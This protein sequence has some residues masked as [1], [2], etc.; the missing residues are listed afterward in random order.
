MIS[1]EFSRPSTSRRQQQVMQALGQRRA[2]RR[3]SPRPETSRASPRRSGSGSGRARSSARWRPAS[4]R[5][6]ND[7]VDRAAAADRRDDAAGMP[8]SAAIATANSDEQRGRLGALH[9]RLRHRPLQ[10]DR[11]AEV[12]L[13][14]LAQPAART[15]PAA[16]CPGRSPSCTRAMSSAVAWSPSST[17]TGSPDA[18]ARQHEDQHRD[19]GQ[20]R[21]A[22]RPG[23]AAG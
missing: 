6:V 20:H 22:C 19:D 11:L 14:Q 5:R 8:I 10:E 2:R 17:A 1:A 13:Q 12:A 9:Q 4:R 16:A 18:S 21:P 15:A 7:L 3:H 23:R